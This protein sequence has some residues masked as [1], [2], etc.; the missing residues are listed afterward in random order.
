MHKEIFE[1]LSLETSLPLLSDGHPEHCKPINWYCQLLLVVES[2]ITLM[3]TWWALACLSSHSRVKEGHSPVPPGTHTI[4]LRGITSPS[5]VLLT[6]LWCSLVYNNESN[7]SHKRIDESLTEWFQT[8]F[9]S[10]LS[11]T[12]NRTYGKHLLL[13]F[14]CYFLQPIFPYF[15]FTSPWKAIVPFRGDSPTISSPPGLAY[16][17]HY[18]QKWLTGCS[19]L[20]GH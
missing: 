20:P 16:T 1:L 14:S 5:R 6:A 3:S 2:Q 19:L 11:V 8:R 10:K 12:K 18:L 9:H 4:V 17:W 13:L 15:L 7:I